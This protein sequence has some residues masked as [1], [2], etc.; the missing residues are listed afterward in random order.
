ML[1]CTEGMVSTREWGSSSGLAPPPTPAAHLELLL[2]GENV[3]PSVVPARPE[4][5][6]DTE[7]D[8]HVLGG[9]DIHHL[10]R[11]QK[12]GEASSVSPRPSWSTGRR[13]PPRG[14]T[15][16]SSPCAAPTPPRPGRW[17]AT[18]RR[19]GDTTKPCVS[20]LSFTWE[21]FMEE[22]PSE[23]VKDILAWRKR[24]VVTR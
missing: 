1:P 4:A 14:R 16:Q 12:T 9:V 24:W 8:H 5:V 6:V 18:R 20:Y 11:R 17:P 19:S 23:G 15:C 13:L 3:D 7:E 10:G 22:P 21:T 2:P